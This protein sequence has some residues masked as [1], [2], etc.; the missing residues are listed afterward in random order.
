MLDDPG[1][2]IQLDDSNE[3]P[4]AFIEV[5]SKPSCFVELMKI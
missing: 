1:G 2:P 5:Y 4:F 3:V